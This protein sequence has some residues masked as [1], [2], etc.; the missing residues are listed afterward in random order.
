MVHFKVLPLHFHGGTEETH[1]KPQNNRS[2]GRNVNPGPPEHEVGM[3]T[4]R[5][6]P[7]VILRYKN[8]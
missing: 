6:R 3:L 8:I 5:L 7:S 2:A 1:E 4:T